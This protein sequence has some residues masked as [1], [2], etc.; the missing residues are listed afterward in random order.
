MPVGISAEALLEQWA[1]REA[2]PEGAAVVLDVEIAARTRG[3]AEWRQQDAVAVAVLG[4]PASLA[5]EQADLAWAAASL[6]A[7]R[8]LDDLSGG[9]HDCLWPDQVSGSRLEAEVAVSARTALGPGHVNHVSL[10]ARVGPWPS[11]T[12]DQLSRVL[13]NRLREV[14]AALGDPTSVLND[15]RT[16]CALID[17]HVEIDLLPHG[18]LRGRVIT[19]DEACSLVLVSPTGLRE[20][21]PLQAVARV[22]VSAPPSATG[23]DPL[24][25]GGATNQTP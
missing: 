3:G 8:A 21:V 2:A 18:S 25:S 11:A 24:D 5:V 19:V 6:G 23:A 4:R 9:P 10:V 22:R 14:A 20:R 16:R 1:R 15:Y 12:R 7:A 13:V 17:E